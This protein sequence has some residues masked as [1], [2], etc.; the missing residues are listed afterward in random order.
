MN[1]LMYC[2]S[3]VSGGA[4]AY[5]R[6]LAPLLAK[7]FSLGE[8]RLKFLLHE[9][10]EP[11]FAGIEEASFS[12]IRGKRS[13]GA[14]RIWWE[15]K[16]MNRI[17]SEHNI[18]VLFTPYQIAAHVPDVRQVLMLRNME[19]FLFDAYNYSIT[20]WLRNQVLRQNSVRCLKKANRVIAVSGFAR[21]HLVEKM[22]VD[23]ERVRTIYHGSPD[24][25]FGAEKDMKILS[26]YGIDSDYLFTCGSLLP[27]R[28]C[29]DIILAF[30]QCATK[31]KRDV[32]L[33][34]VGSGTDQGYRRKLLQLIESSIVREQILFLGQV[35]WET[36]TSLYRNCMAC[37]IATEIEACP[38][39]AIEAMAAGCAIISSDKPPLPEMFQRCSQEYKARNLNQLAIKI[40]EVAD[41]SAWRQQLKENA[42]KRSERFSWGECALKTYDALVNW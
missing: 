8:N 31:L 15:R 26:K 24:M 10:Q 35:S 36:M 42:R 27:Y 1:V 30:A 9:E 32:Q 5:L 11:L 22:G 21:E 20:N 17:V 13:K 38:N 16:H 23:A 2:L 41:D 12:W 39:I 18:D 34:I 28:R 25:Q 6:N 33:V 14:E 19:P 37:I 29:E 40:Q 7:R 3:S 4:V